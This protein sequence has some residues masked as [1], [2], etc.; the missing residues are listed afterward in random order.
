[1]LA[2]RISYL[3]F[4]TQRSKKNSSTAKENVPF[5]FLFYD[6]QGL[7]IH[8]NINSYLLLNYLKLLHI[9]YIRD[10]FDEFNFI[11]II[12]YFLIFLKNKNRTLKY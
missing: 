1:M 7:Q 10:D 4:Y 11:Y 6:C 2:H 5:N 8:R 3:F 12:L 9:S